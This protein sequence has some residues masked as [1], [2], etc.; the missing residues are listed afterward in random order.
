MNKKTP[1]PL[2]EKGHQFATVLSTVLFAVVYLLFY[3]E[4]S[5][6]VWFELGKS[7]YF[8]FTLGFISIATVFVIISRTIMYNL[9]RVPFFPIWLYVIWILLEILVIACFY[10]Y[11]TAYHIKEDPSYYW[12]IFPKSLIS[13]A[14]ILIVPYI[15]TI[16]YTL[17]N[18]KGKTLRV[19][20][21]EDSS[22]SNISDFKGG[23]EIINLADNN[24]NVKL[25]LRLDSL[26]YIVSQDNYIKIY[27]ISNEGLSNYLLRCKIKTVEESFADTSLIRCHRSYI[28]N[29]DKISAIKKGKEGT[30][31]ELNIEGVSPIPLSNSYISNFQQFFS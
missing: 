8:F 17:S 13:V 7:V 27:Y 29:S 10:A 18:I 4:S 15:S 30:F 25:S 11:V 28:V 2:L 5:T 24:G 6:T 12:T 14:I 1:I 22:V 23:A 3:K 26:I 20:K 21:F 31:I 9:R 19:L 16:I